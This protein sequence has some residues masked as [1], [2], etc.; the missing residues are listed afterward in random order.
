MNFFSKISHQRNLKG[1]ALLWVIAAAIFVIVALPLL[2]VEALLETPEEVSGYALFFCI[3]F[4]GFFRVRKHLSMFSLIKTRWWFAAHTIGGLLAV[5][6][7]ILHVDSWWPHSGYVQLL[8]LLMILVTIS[9]MLGYLIQTIFPPR[10]TQQGSEI[11]FSQIPEAVSQV[12]IA[13]EELMLEANKVTGHETLARH[14]LE[15]LKWFFQK[16]RFVLS[17]IF[18][19]RQADHWL[20]QQFVTVERYLDKTEKEYSARLEKLARKKL[21]IDFNYAIQGLLQYWLLFHVPLSAALIVMSLWHL[22]LVNI[23][24]L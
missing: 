5:A 1:L 4:L 18:G 15:T 10:L 17:H 20:S 8:A 24:I 16:P 9:G 22:L 11:L 13:A 6:F 12:K 19:G 7:Y 3:L 2:K 21:D 14:Y 23:Y